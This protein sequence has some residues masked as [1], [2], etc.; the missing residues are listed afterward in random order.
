M[1]VR[2]LVDPTDASD[3][4]QETPHFRLGPVK[5]AA[6][7]ACPRRTK[8]LATGKQRTNARPGFFVGGR[9]FHLVLWPPDP[10]AVER[11]FSLLRKSLQ[12]RQKC[13]R[14]YARLKLQAQ[15][16]KPDAGQIRIFP[17]ELF[18]RRH[19]SALKAH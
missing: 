4:L 19:Q 3:E 17:V 18:E 13:R 9:E 7:V 8:A 12:N 10:G 5:N 11:D 2:D 6:D 16:F 14:R 1:I 15:P